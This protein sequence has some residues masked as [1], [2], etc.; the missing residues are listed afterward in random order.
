MSLH[1][2][3]LSAAILGQEPTFLVRMCRKKS[4]ALLMAKLQHMQVIRIEIIIQEHKMRKTIKK[5][6]WS[7]VFLCVITKWQL[8]PR[9]NKH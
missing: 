2:A 7:I 5:N 1:S 8:L 6:Y 9:L 3:L 4:D